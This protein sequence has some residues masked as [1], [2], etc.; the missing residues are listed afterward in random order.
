MLSKLKT[1]LGINDNNRDELLEVL[2]DSVCGRICAYI[3]EDSVPEELQN[4]VVE[5]CIIRF[6]R[7]GSEG[8]TSHTIEGESLNFES[9][10]FKGFKNEIQAW[11]N[12]QKGKRAGKVV[13]L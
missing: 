12:A 2:I 9:D 10:D 1:L 7:I 5:M 8:L 11:L 3:G 4:V 6:N 13:F